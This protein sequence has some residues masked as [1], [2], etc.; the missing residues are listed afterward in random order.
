MVFLLVSVGGGGYVM[1]VMAMVIVTVD[2]IVVGSD[3]SSDASNGC[4][5]VNSS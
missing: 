1:K 3:G 2:G 5:N 4:V